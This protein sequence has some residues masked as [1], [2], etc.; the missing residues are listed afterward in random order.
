V[1][2]TGGGRGPS[3]VAQ[4]NLVDEDEGATD[5]ASS[6]SCEVP[7]ALGAGSRP[8]VNRTSRRPLSQNLLAGDGDRDRGAARFGAGASAGAVSPEHATH[9]ARTASP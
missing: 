7:A 1:S 5:G 8:R 2:G 4:G 9:A 6:L 3:T